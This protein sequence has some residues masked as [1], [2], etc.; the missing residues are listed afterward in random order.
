MFRVLNDV[1]LLDNESSLK[2]YDYVQAM[3]GVDIAMQCLASLSHRNTFDLIIMSGYRGSSDNMRINTEDTVEMIRTLKAYQNVPIIII[4]HQCYSGTYQ[5][6]GV[7]AWIGVN[8]SHDEFVTAIKASMQV[9][10]KKAP[11]QTSGENW[12]LVGWL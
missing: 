3:S 1:F 10:Q 2:M 8:A 4:D 11:T 5:R 9:G 6:I 7:T 12:K